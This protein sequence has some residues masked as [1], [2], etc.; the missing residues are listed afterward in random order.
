M[1]NTMKLF[2]KSNATVDDIKSLQTLLSAH[3]FIAYDFEK[4]HKD[5][6]KDTFKIAHVGITAQHSNNGKGTLIAVW[7]TNK[8]T[9]KAYNV[10]ISNDLHNVLSTK[11]DTIK[12]LLDNASYKDSDELCI[13]FYSLKDVYSFFETLFRYLETIES[14]KE[15]KAIE[16]SESVTA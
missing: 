11:S 4:Y 13:K 1:S 8:A 6:A 5:V 16:K 2:T 3:K 10:R 9:D 12:F 7:N 15:V 14:K